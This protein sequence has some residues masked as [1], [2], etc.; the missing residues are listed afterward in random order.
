M[1]VQLRKDEAMSAVLKDMAMAEVHQTAVTVAPDGDG[2]PTAPPGAWADGVDALV[3]LLRYP[4]KV[5]VCPLSDLPDRNDLPV[6]WNQVAPRLKAVLEQNE[7]RAV[8]AYLTLRLALSVLTTN[9]M[10]LRRGPLNIQFWQDECGTPIA[11][12]TVTVDA[13]TYRAA[14]LRDDLRRLVCACHAG[15]CGFGVNYR[16]TEPYDPSH[17]PPRPTRDIDASDDEE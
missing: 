9:H 17:W 13:N 4:E 3:H 12:V 15:A 16:S 14:R 6:D 5:H 1:N 8:D 7:I 11:M 2:L 10:A